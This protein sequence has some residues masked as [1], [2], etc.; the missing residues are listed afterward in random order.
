MA[1]SLSKFK[2]EGAR[3]TVAEKLAKQY[4]VQ[5]K[6][7]Q[8]RKGWSGLLGKGLGMLAGTALAGMTGG[9]AAPLLMAAGTFGGRKLAHEATRGM[10]AD[11]GA[12]SGGDKYG[13]GKEEAKT[14]KEMLKSQMAVDPMKEHGG[15]G[16][17]VLSSYL[18]AGMAGE[19][20][21][22]KEFLKGDVGAK[23]ALFGKEGFKGVSGAKEA[24]FGKA[25][26]EVYSPVHPGGV[27]ETEAV[28]VYPDMPST[29]TES[30]TGL[31][32]EQV[33]EPVNVMSQ[34]LTEENTG[35]LSPDWTGAHGGLVP[36]K[37]PT[38]SDY[39]GMQ[40]VSLGGSNKQ[41]LAEMLGR[42]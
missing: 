1:I 14:L 9:L 11:V 27:L 26:E 18:S 19:L 32:F 21:G 38:I 39:F 30:Y 35:P 6:R 12:I 22:A 20:G 8:K 41:S 4:E 2:Q 7:A 42:R 28:G 16:K 5:Q 34:Y 17:D 31:P 13:Y 33:E 15:F 24:L 23:E 25:A 37:S 40:G 3:R 29:I 36:T 10:G